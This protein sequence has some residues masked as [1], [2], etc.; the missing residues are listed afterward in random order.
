MATHFKVGDK[1]KLVT[2]K[3]GDSATNPVVLTEDNLASAYEAMRHYA[4]SPL[5]WDHY[6]MVD[7]LESNNKSNRMQ[8]LTKTLRRVLKPNM[9]AIYKAG[10]IN[11]D[12]ELTEEG[13]SA[14]NT[15]L[16]EQ[17]EEQLAELAKA[18]IKEMKEEK[19]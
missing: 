14:L 6:P 11:G 12:L 7:H 17:Y 4:Y 1:V 15:I 18:D 10:Y 8:K 9:R 13:K 3:Y 2:S 5:S 19:K 16:L